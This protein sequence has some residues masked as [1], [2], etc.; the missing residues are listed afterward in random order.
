MVLKIDPE[1]EKLMTPLTEDEFQQLK[2]NIL[3]EGKILQPICIWNGVIVDGHNRYRIAQRYPHI[4]F[5]VCE[6]EFEDRFAAMTWMCKNQL[7]RRNLTPELWS[8][9]LGKRYDTARLRQG[10]H[11]QYVQRKSESDQNDHFHSGKICEQ[12]A[13]ENNCGSA[14]VRRAAKFAKGLDLADEIDPGIRQD[15]LSRKIRPTQ[16]S[17]AAVAK[18]EPH[19]RAALV[20]MLRKNPNRKSA[21]PTKKEVEEVANAM[22]YSDESDTLESVVTELDSALKA[23]MF[24][25]S[26]C[27]RN[28]PSIFH[29]E[30]CKSEICKLTQIGFDFMKQINEGELPNDDNRI[31]QSGDDDLQQP[32]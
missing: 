13:A 8:Y 11:N 32:S 30:Q 4:T 16:E 5:S 10:T 7:G 25:W 31:H 19:K 9:F 23:M 17:V 21:K 12:I 14:T 6:M 27:L 29:S 24:R 22:I 26:F 3:T 18:A 28:N 15:V 2:E 20:A 1:F